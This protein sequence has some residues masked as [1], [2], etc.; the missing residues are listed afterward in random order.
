MFRMKILKVF[1]LCSM[2]EDNCPCKPVYDAKLNITS[3]ERRYIM[4]IMSDF[5]QIQQQCIDRLYHSG[6]DA[7]CGEG[8]FI[9]D[10]ESGVME[11]TTMG[12]CKG[13]HKMRKDIDPLPPIIMINVN[14]ADYDSSRVKV[15]CKLGWATL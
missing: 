8:A 7:P 5:H 11:A 2:F 4:A 6:V 14:D 3:G 10:L 9:T 15:W 13:V 12:L 1:E